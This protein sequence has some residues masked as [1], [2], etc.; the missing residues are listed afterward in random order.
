[1]S[2]LFPFGRLLIALLPQLQGVFTEP[3]LTI[4]GVLDLFPIINSPRLHSATSPLKSLSR[5]ASYALTTVLIGVTCSWGNMFTISGG[6][7]LVMTKDGHM[8]L[9]V[10]P[11][12]ARAGPA[13]RVRPTRPCFAPMCWALIGEAL[14]WTTRINQSMVTQLQTKYERWWICPARRCDSTY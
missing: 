12:G 11:V 8:Q 9:T 13:L 3:P 5:K 4:I 6:H 2:V 10:T 14:L 1:M 7:K